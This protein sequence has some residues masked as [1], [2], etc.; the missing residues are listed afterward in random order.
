MVWLA[1][2]STAS[3]TSSATSSAWLV[4]QRAVGRHVAHGGLRVG[5]AGGELDDDRVAVA[6][7]VDDRGRQCPEGRVLQE[8]H[9]RF[10]VTDEAGAVAD[11]FVDVE[12][13]IRDRAV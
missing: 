8:E 4:H 5:A 1:V 10:G 3:V 2:A 13:Q 11:A 7:G 6:A 12:Q 9:V